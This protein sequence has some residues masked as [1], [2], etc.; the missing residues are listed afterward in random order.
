MLGGAHRGAKFF[1]LGPL[2]V[3]VVAD[4]PLFLGSDGKKNNKINVGGVLYAQL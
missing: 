1:L 4:V 2:G 3:R